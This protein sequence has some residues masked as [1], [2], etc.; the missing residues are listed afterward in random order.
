MSQGPRAGDAP[1]RLVIWDVDGTLVDSQHNIVAAMHLAC[2][3]HGILPP[4][5]EHVRRGIGLSLVEAVA[6]ALTD[7][8]TATH[9]RIAKAYQEAFFTLRAR[10]DH[11]EHL[12]PGAAEALRRLDAA[13]LL[14]GMA[15]GKSRRGVDHFVSHWA[16]EDLFVT[17][18]CVDDCPGKPHPAMIQRALAE[19][20][21]DPRLTVM[22]GDTTFDMMM[23]RNAGVGAIGVTWGNHPASD[24]HRAG[25]HVVIDSFDDLDAAIDALTTGDRSKGDTEPCVS[26]ES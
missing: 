21:C 26:A 12:F 24:L 25:A 16:L 7:H 15:T 6:Q 19:T 11:V 20:G 9:E 22:V 18:Q 8:D 13:G 1:L 2:E 23:A 5:P 4:P 10:P 3:Q 14:L 17:L